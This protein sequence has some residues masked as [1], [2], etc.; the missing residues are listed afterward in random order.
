MDESVFARIFEPFF[1][2]RANGNGFGLASTRDIVRE[3]GG[4]MHVE[5]AVSVGTRFEVWLPYLD[6][7]RPG[8]TTS[9]LFGHGETVLLVECDARQ[10]LHDEEILAALG[11]EPVGYDIAADAL[12]ACEASPQRFDL[13]LL[14]DPTAVAEMLELSG[15]LRRLVP[16]VPILLA[17]FSADAVD[18]AELMRAGVV[19]VLPWPIAAGGTIAILQDTLRR[20]SMSR[21]LI[22]GGAP[23]LAAP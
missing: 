8:V 19:D 2:T 3:H 12:A 15:R 16:G 23:P 6:A 7:G 22:I 5:S 9:L 1:T 18:V 4:A 13:I 17:T 11:Y 14:A 21:S 10:R 20:S